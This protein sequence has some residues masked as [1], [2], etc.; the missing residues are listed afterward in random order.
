MKKVGWYLMGM[1]P[2]LAM[3]ATQFFGSIVFAVGM[4][5][6]QGPE[7]AGQAYVDD[8]MGV[9]LVIDLMC[10]LISGL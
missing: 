1:V 6:N 4:I 7:A 5:L 3:L 8:I 2:L 10:L 9:M